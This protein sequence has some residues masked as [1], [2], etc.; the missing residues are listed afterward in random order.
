MIK[1]AAPIELKTG[2]FGI[3]DT[4]FNERIRDNYAVIGS[5]ITAE[6]LT[7]MLHTSPDILIAE[8]SESTTNIGGNAFSFTNIQQ[9]LINSAVNRIIISGDYELNYQ[10]RVFIT[11]VLNKLGI[12]DERR[13]MNEVRDILSETSNTLALTKLYMNNAEEIRNLIEYERNNAPVATESD[14]SE[15][16][17]DSFENRLYLNIMN[18]LQTGSIYQIMENMSVSQIDAQVNREEVLNS[19]QS[20]T[21]RQLL[22]QRYRSITLNSDVPMVYRADNVFEEETLDAEPVSEEKVKEIVN[23]AAFLEVIRNIDHAYALKTESDRR[24]WTDYRNSFYRSADNIISRILIGIRE[25]RSAFRF[26][27]TALSFVDESERKEINALMSI[28]SV[29]DFSEEV[30]SKAFLTYFQNSSEIERELDEKEYLIERLEESGYEI[31]ETLREEMLTRMNVD[32]LMERSVQLFSEARMS[33]LENYS[34]EERERIEREDLVERLTESGYVL[35]ESEKKEILEKL[36]IENIRER[37]REQF[38][39]ALRSNVDS[40]YVQ[41]RETVE[42]EVV[43]E[44]IKETERSRETVEKRNFESV[45]TSFLASHENETF[46]EQL[47]RIN[48]NNRSNI[49]RYKE[50][51]Q[52]LLTEEKTSSIKSDRERTIRESLKSLN[53]KEHLLKLIESMDKTE[54]I[55]VDKK[56]ERIYRLLPTE[57]VEILKQIEARGS[58]KPENT[59]T[60]NEVALEESQINNYVTEVKE[61]TPAEM[62]YESSEYGEESEITVD[63]ED[64]T[65]EIVDRVLEETGI[66]E[67]VSSYEL[68]L[69]REINRERIAIEEAER[70]SRIGAGP[71]E[72][73]Y[74]ENIISEGGKVT[75]SS[76]IYTESPREF[77]SLAHMIYKINE[78]LTEEDVMERLEEF[79]RT[80]SREKTVINETREP[81]QTFKNV[82]PAAVQA[83]APFQLGKVEQEEISELVE[84]GVRRQINFISNEVYTRLE[85]RLKSEK[86]RRGY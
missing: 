53:D 22:L 50:I 76:T 29:K 21:A 33:V 25:Q 85:K 38:R 42:R 62:T 67:T 31:D 81:V 37:T 17:R 79:R 46:S 14:E 11:S 83:Q 48:N 5:N 69:N 75:A 36:D 35:S 18:R 71:A 84:R 73:E 52:I 60:V 61:Y 45:S 19:E 2:G 86:A 9:T 51:R 30:F 7:H 64:L 54:S 43:S 27:K 58:G 10:D 28:E 16:S 3:K 1:L 6:T 78:T 82:T 77:R 24:Y 49:E 63:D 70:L 8:G 40:F 13:F 39:E 4:G 56:L 55:T 47:E 41:D 34:N 12:R 66:L 23:S 72:M 80:V 68:L 26:E 44:Q 32:T 65:Q 20:Y 15:V 57:T 59:A 74:L